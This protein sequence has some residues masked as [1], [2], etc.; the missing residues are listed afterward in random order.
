MYHRFAKAYGWTPAQVD[1]TDAELCD[2]LL[3]IQ[4]VEA[5]IQQEEWQALLA[6]R[7]HLR[8]ICD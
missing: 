5:E 3:A 1:E 2:W 7:S 8:I 6:C 4:G